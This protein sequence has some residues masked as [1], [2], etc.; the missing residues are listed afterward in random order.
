MMDYKDMTT[1]MALNL[2][3]FSDASS[4]SIDAMNASSNDWVLDVPD[5]YKTRYFLCYEHIE[6]VLDGSETCSLNCWKA[7]SEIP[8][9]YN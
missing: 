1:P 6:P 8:E 3:L 5:K 9:G 7:Y 2:K 4:E